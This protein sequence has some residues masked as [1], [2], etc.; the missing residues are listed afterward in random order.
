MHLPR[1]KPGKEVGGAGK[2]VPITIF[3]AMDQV[4]RGICEIRPL[5][6]ST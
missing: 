6:G 3:N 5:Y 1:Q 2:T 4:F